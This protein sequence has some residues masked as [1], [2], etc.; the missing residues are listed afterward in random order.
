VVHVVAT[1]TGVCIRGARISTFLLAHQKIKVNIASNMGIWGMKKTTI[2]IPDALMQ[3]VKMR[4][5]VRQQK[6]KD[7]VAQLLELGMA[8]SGDEGRPRRAPKPVRLKGGTSLNF[9]D[10]E[11]AI[12]SG[13]D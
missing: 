4:A 2:E 3:R 11:V 1:S 6:L 12:D 7:V 8:A 10:I 9:C 13:R 5:V